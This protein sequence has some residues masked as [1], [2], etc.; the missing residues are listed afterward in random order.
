MT[1]LQCRSLATGCTKAIKTVQLSGVKI[2]K[3]IST[4]V[5]ALGLTLWLLPMAAPSAEESAQSEDGS[6]PAAK[7]LEAAVNPVTGDAVCVNPR[8]APVEPPPKS[9]YQPCKPRAH[10]DDPFT[11][12]EHASGC[13]D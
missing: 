10:D 4:L 12:Y 9:A 8:G 2:V 6:A 5:L 13:G 11:V 7:C 1:H 3:H